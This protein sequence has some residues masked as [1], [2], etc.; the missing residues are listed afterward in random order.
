MA[1]RRRPPRR[2]TPA[3]PPPRPRPSG[4]AVD[5]LALA[6][7]LTAGRLAI[8]AAMVALP[9]PSMAP[10]LGADARRPATQVGLRAFGMRE[11]F[12]GALGM[13]VASRP[14]VGRRT[15]GG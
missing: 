6:R 5:A 15:I 8:G 11:L 1:P 2:P 12:L 10:W 3:R 9:G 4:R 7:G 13:H 14:G